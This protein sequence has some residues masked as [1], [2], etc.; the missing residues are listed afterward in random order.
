[1]FGDKV[2]IGMK[3]EIKRAEELG[4]NVRRLPEPGR[5][6]EL[7]LRELERQAAKTMAGEDEAVGT[8][9]DG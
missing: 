1:M 9:A 7:L 6:A 8:E 4:K 3:A 5:M 2:S